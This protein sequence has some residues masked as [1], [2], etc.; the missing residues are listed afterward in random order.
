[1]PKSAPVHC[2]TSTDT[3]F[4]S[5]YPGPKHKQL[6]WTRVRRKER[7]SD[8]NESTFTQQQ[9][10]GHSGEQVEGQ[11]RMDPI[12]PA[13]LRCWEPVV[14]SQAVWHL[15]S[16]ERLPWARQTSLPPL[17][18]LLSLPSSAGHTVLSRTHCSRLNIISVDAVVATSHRF[19]R[20]PPAP[21]PNKNPPLTPVLSPF[22]PPAPPSGVRKSWELTPGQVSCEEGRQGPC[23]ISKSWLTPA[24]SLDKAIWS[25]LPA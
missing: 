16:V 3:W 19:L 1:M 15:S 7:K 5:L 21:P 4:R 23:G 13:S 2:W 14:T 6:T 18:E 25:P 9:P 20:R 11:A 10:C 8:R 24:S 22:L 17:P 12:K